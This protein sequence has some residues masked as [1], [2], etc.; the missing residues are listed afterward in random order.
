[1]MMKRIILPLAFFL[2][3][4]SPA[5]AQ[6]IP[7]F[8]RIR[9]PTSPAFVVLGV[10]PAQVERPTAPADFSASLLNT[11]RS[12]A[13]PGSWA[14]ETTPYWWRSH[15]RLTLREY[16]HGG[17]A[18]SFVRNLSI[19][20]AIS[21][22]VPERFGPP[23]DLPDFRR[24]GLGA[25]TTLWDGAPADTTCVLQI[26]AAAT[27]ASQLKGAVVAAALARDASITTRAGA[28]DSLHRASVREAREALPDADRAVISDSSA[29]ACG[30]KLAARRGL[31]VDGALG[32]GLS[33]SEGPLTDGDLTTLGVWLTP[34][35]LWRNASLVGVV[36]GMWDEL[37][38]DTTR[39]DFDIG[40]RGVYAW[41]RH[42]VSLETVFRRTTRGD[43][44]DDYMRVS[45]SFD[46][47][48]A[49]NTWLNLTFGR[50][51]DADRPGSL[52][53]IANVQWNV[54]KRRIRPDNTIR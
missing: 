54:G 48:V 21:D 42:A 12:G 25:R 26:N 35:H 44:D 45:L 51:L 22:S 14:A 32:A 39:F 23:G 15:P 5:A 4:T 37:E 53:T 40:G 52:L 31:V 38:A 28:L 50:D 41:S 49:E 18:A 43:E 47:E 8:N 27:R 17:P 7:E 2:T 11:F 33:F 9:T 46:T 16:L 6:D 34:A 29:I 10:A 3:A 1:M 20:L 30:E 13:A 24:L 36:R 19:S